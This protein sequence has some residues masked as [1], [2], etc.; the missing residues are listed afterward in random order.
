LG[1]E[2]MKIGLPQFQQ[3]REQWL[4]KMLTQPFRES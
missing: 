2:G 1:H 3:S 4:D